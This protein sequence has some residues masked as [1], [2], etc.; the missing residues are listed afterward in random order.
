[1]PSELY[2]PSY[3]NTISCYRCDLQIEVGN[4]GLEREQLRFRDLSEREL[5]FS[6]SL[7]DV[8]S[9]DSMRD[10]SGVGWTPT[11]CVRTLFDTHRKYS[12]GCSISHER[13]SDQPM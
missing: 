13:R 9:E 4:G 1:M 2:D 5:C 12:N 11:S 7:E 6:Q 10:L 8:L 3:L